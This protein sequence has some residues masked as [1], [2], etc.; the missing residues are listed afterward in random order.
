MTAPTPS[1]VATAEPVLIAH[2]ITA[3]LAALV[4]TGW[5]AFPSQSVLDVIGTGL[6]LLVATVGAFV[7]RGQVTPTGS[8]AAPT[9]AE[10]E[11]A[12]HDIATRIT[13]EQI[14]TYVA[15]NG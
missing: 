5:I 1:P 3:F 13:Q 7:A 9:W 14:D 6:A 12:I 15:K 8:A 2:A 11:Q 10:I 4:A